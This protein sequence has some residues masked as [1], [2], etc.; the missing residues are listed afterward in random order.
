MQGWETKLGWRLLCRQLRAF[1]ELETQ[2]G[3][4]VVL[5][6]PKISSRNHCSGVTSR[7][8]DVWLPP[9]LSNAGPPLP[10]GNIP[11]LRSQSPFLKELSPWQREK[12]KPSS[13]CSRGP[14]RHAPRSDWE[15]GAATGRQLDGA[16]TSCARALPSLAFTRQGRR[17]CPRRSRA[18]AG[19]GRRAGTDGAGHQ[20]PF[21]GTYCSLCPSPDL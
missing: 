6:G 8:R 17:R 9:A 18:G 5:K 19:W 20:H 7:R 3:D 15:G 21:P 13:I 10:K 2:K 1:Q 14:G 4:R 11:L 12:V 16:A